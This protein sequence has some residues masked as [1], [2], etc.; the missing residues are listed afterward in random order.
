MTD[1]SEHIPVTGGRIDIWQRDDGLFAVSLLPDEGHPGYP[2]VTYTSG[3]DAPD[4]FPK[5]YDVAALRTW[6]RQQ[7]AR[8]AH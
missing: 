8:F 7:W 4:D 5:T 2:G 1:R 6:G 3:G